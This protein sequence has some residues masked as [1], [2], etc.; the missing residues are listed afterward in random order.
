MRRT[1]YQPNGRLYS[2]TFAIKRCSWTGR[3]YTILNRH[4]IKNYKLKPTG[5][6]SRMRTLLDRKLNA[7]IISRSRN[8][9]C[10]DVKGVS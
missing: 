1:N 8:L 10:C 3:C 6:R 2:I 7:A 9:D 5:T 4:D